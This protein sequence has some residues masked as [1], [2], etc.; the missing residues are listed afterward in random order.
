M[1]ESFRG[2]K[3]NVVKV[4]GAT[5]TGFGKRESTLNINEIFIDKIK[6][7]KPDYICFALGQVDIELGLYYRSVVKGEKV[8]IME[9]INDLV[10][11]Y[12][13][14]INNLQ[15]ETGFSASN[16]SVKGINYSVLTKSRKKAINYT[17]RIITENVEDESLANVYKEK[18]SD[19]F[20]SNIER[21][22]M[23]QEMNK[24]IELMCKGCFNYFDVNDYFLDKKNIG[25]YK[26]EFLPAGRD[27]HLVDSLYVREV[28]VESL[29]S[30][31]VENK[32][33]RK[34]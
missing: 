32:F 30:S 34:I 29:I 3:I 2:V 26:K 22:F 25:Q 5:I 1:N 9:F 19:V 31:F 21:F 18:L 13:F 6:V 7:F 23:H 27:H 33:D 15:K 17:S 10:S 8:N 24:K 16:I 11:K 14:S 20:P 12:L 4:S 28:F